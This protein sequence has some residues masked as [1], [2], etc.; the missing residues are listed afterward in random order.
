MTIEKI[1][2]PTLLEPVG[3]SHVVVAA[4]TRRIY[5]AGQTG[6]D[7]TGKVVGIDYASQAAQAYRNLGAALE[8]AGATWDDV[9]KMNIL[10]V[11][12]SAAATEAIFGAAFLVFGETLPSPAVTLY[13][14]QALFEPEF[15]IEIDAIAEK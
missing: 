1:N 2:P 11:N 6:V 4:G 12:H 5:I 7:I 3:F 13:G 14:V 9:V 8:A 15:L 10:V